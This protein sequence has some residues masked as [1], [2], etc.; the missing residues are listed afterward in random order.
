MKIRNTDHDAQCDWPDNIRIQ[1]GSSGL[2]IR[3]PGSFE[4]FTSAFLT[5]DKESLRTE[6]SNTYTTA[7]VEVFTHDTFI[8]GEG[9]TVEEAEAVAFKK[10]Q[11]QSAC[12]GHKYEARNYQNGCGFCI[13]CNHFGSGVF[14]A[15]DL[16]Q[17]CW[18]CDTPT[19]HYWGNHG[20]EK[21]F[22]CPDHK[23]RTKIDSLLG[24]VRNA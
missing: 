10:F 6:M 7:F 21:I 12:P 3:K 14:T 22:A 2:V 23:P 13:H 1:G 9:V 24:E 19:M 15:E 5:G 17:Y 20:D 8:R 18:Y 16:G 4:G 11:R